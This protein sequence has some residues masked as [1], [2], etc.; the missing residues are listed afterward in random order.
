MSEVGYMAHRQKIL[1]TPDLEH[2]DQAHFH[3]F[4]KYFLTVGLLTVL[5]LTDTKAAFVCCLSSS[6]S[7]FSG[8]SNFLY[9]IL[10]TFPC[11]I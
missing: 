1:H 4:L 5:Q 8:S 11:D 9:F 10:V 7:C 2:Q 6:K 3:H